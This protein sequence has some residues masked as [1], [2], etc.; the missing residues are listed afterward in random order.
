MKSDQEIL[1]Y[2]LSY[3]TEN[4]RKLFKEVIEKRTNH[5]T[6]VLEDIF[7]PHNAS[8]VLRSCDVYGIQDVHVIENYNKYK[9]NPKV[10][11]GATKWINMIKY[12]GAEDN[13]LRCINQLKA[14]GY[15]IIATTPHHNDYDIADLPIDEKV[16]LMFGTELTGLSQVAIDNADSFVRIPMYGFTESLNISVCA[17]ISLYELSKRLRNSEIKWQ[18]TEEEKLQQLL[19]WTKKIVKSSDLLI[20]KFN[21]SAE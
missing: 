12:N 2:L 10:V 16:A 3:A 19:K 6:V 9:I 20:S 1:D 8:A 4:K 5:I 15:K 14:D 7:Q 18:L 21:A 13:T 17:A 11:M